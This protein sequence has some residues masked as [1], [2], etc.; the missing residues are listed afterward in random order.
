MI[1]FNDTAIHLPSNLLRQ[2]KLCSQLSLGIT[3]VSLLQVGPINA[4][5]KCSPC[6]SLLGRLMVTNISCSCILLYSPELSC[7]TLVFSCALL[8]STVHSCI[9]LCTLVFFYA[10]LYSPVHSCILLCTLV[11]FLYTPV[12]AGPDVMLSALSHRCTSTKG[13]LFCLGRTKEC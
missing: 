6:R 11:F 3:G 9:L 12:Y 7:Y 13:L 4:C 5:Y 8:Y 1:Y 10:V 2:R